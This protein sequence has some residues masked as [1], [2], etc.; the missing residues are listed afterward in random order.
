MGTKSLTPM[1]GQISFRNGV[2]EI[3]RTRRNFDDEECE[4]EDWLN[5]HVD[6]KWGCDIYP[7]VYYCDEDCPSL[8][9]YLLCPETERCDDDDDFDPETMRNADDDE[10]DLEAVITL[11][12]GESGDCDVRNLNVVKNGQ[13]DFTV[14]WIHPAGSHPTYVVVVYPPID[15][16][17]SKAR[18]PDCGACADE[19]GCICGSQPLFRMHIDGGQTSCDFPVECLEAGKTFI[20]EVATL[21]GDRDESFGTSLVMIDVYELNK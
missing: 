11:R 5:W 8:L 21:N 7:E 14:S 2:E 19:D 17:G 4:G 20:V 13:D 18:G 10:Q 6:A 9:E 16:A 3:G 1:S 12:Q 15:S